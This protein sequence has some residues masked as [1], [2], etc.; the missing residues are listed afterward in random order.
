[1]TTKIDLRRMVLRHLT[2]IDATEDPDAEQ[3]ANADL[4]IDAARA[5]LLEKTVCW[6]DE[7]D[8]PAAVT[9]PLS[10]Y[11]AAL[12]CASFGRAGKGFEAYEAVGFRQIAAL[13]PSEQRE[14]V[15]GEYS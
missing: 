11:I 10:R 1:V 13:K 8:I 3:A 6:W 12:A 5:M 15:R 9:I 7:N 4:Y 14:T 2:V